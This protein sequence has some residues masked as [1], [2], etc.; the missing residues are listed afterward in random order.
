MG[1]SAIAV[2]F[3]CVTAL[4]S[5]AS[6]EP[7]KSSVEPNAGC[8]DSGRL[9]ARIY[10]PAGCDDDRDCPPGSVCGPPSR[11]EGGAASDDPSACC[12]RNCS[13][14]ESETLVGV[15]PPSC[16]TCCKQARQG[17]AGQC[18]VPDTLT[19]SGTL[20]D[21]FGVDAFPLWQ[22]DTN[23]DS[24]EWQARDDT[25][26][27]TCALFACAPRI[28]DRALVNSDDCVLVRKV[29][30]QSRGVF[31]LTDPTL[32]RFSK[33]A[34]CKAICGADCSTQPT[35]ALAYSFPRNL[36]VG[37][38]AYGDID[39]IGATRLVNV[40]VKR[41]AS[42]SSF[43]VRPNCEATVRVG[44]NGKLET[45]PA[46]GTSCLL[47]G[48]LFGT[49]WKGHCRQRCVNASSCRPPLPASG[50]DSGASARLPSCAEDT[51]AGG[52]A[53]EADHVEYECYRPPNATS[54]V[55]LCVRSC[56]VIAP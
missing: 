8:C 53:S 9:R 55:G 45:V 10:Y 16:T 25:R 2:L 6:D 4:G 56:E 38:W 43:G 19:P 32:R 50:N 49:C 40:D 14:C 33:S 5:C 26:Y 13:E 3:F 42:T 36:S 30:D 1:P 48:D 39:L 35:R 24:F 18:R 29:Y 11:G 12:G 31:D 51:S 7:S 23:G 41:A 52:A 27:V 21:G 37:C 44:T 17:P 20:L 28:E 22:S 46:D 15:G 34:D 47:A 54:Y